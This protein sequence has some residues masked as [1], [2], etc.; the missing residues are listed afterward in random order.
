MATQAHFPATIPTT[1]IKA[2]V[3]AFRAKQLKVALDN[4]LYAAGCVSQM[5][6]D[7]GGWNFGPQAATAE[8]T[9]DQ[10]ADELEGIVSGTPEGAQ[11]AIGSGMLWGLLKA[12]L[13]Q[14]IQSYD[15]T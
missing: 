9:D 10:V 5:L 6:P 12:F 14:L 13:V 15:R 7:S 11:A 2:A 3:A 4:G 1:E 8:M